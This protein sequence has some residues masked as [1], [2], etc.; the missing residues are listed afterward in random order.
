MRT[1]E[2]TSGK[3]AAANASRVRLLTAMAAAAHGGRGHRSAAAVG[4]NPHR[5]DEEEAEA[6]GPLWASDL[7]PT[8]P[9]R[10]QVHPPHI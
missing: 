2:I 8:S 10:Q 7:S 3:L 1:R 6:G 4:E 5:E 9:L